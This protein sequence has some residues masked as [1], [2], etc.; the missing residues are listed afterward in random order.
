VPA[1]TIPYSFS[2][3]TTAQS[4]QVNANFSAVATLL[5]STLL[6]STNIQTGGIATANLA[7]NSVTGA[8]LASSCADGTTLQYT[9]S[10]L[11]IKASGVGTSQIADGAVTQAKR[12]SLGQQ[13]SSSSGA[14]STA[15]TSLTAVTNLSVTIT[16]TGRPLFLG[17]VHDG[18]SNS[19]EFA[20]TGS[21]GTGSGLYE[22][23]DSG[24][25]TAVVHMNPQGAGGT[26]VFTCE[27]TPPW[28]VFVPTAGTYTYTFRVAKT[29][30]T[31]TVTC[32]YMKLVAYE[33]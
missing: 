13:V 25:S 9:S 3:N 20:F 12:A 10:T 18:T 29:G 24:N 19:G 17:L 4:S 21:S 5:N 28:H 2:A 30:S 22:F 6:D 33:L 23:Y 32:A 8:K 16:T 14:Y 11:S 31:S 1:L 27:L 7:A 26:G 15:S